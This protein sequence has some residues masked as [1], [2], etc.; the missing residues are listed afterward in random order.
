MIDERVL[1]SLVTHAGRETARRMIARFVELSP[2][3]RRELSEARD[4]ARIGQ[5]A[6]DVVTSAGA[7]GLME[8]SGE[9]ERLEKLAASADDS[10]VRALAQALISDLERGER[11]LAE[12]AAKL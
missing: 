4:T 11:A 1:Q 6:H 3:W 8:I 7:V 10:Q 2:G 12:K 5:I 9:A